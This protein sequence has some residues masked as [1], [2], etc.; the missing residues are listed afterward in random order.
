MTEDTNGTAG[1]KDVASKE[2]EMLVNA[3]KKG[4]LA[5]LFTFVRLSGPGWLQSA[6]TIGGGSLSNSLY[7]GVLVGFGCLWVQPLAMILGVVMLSAITYVT[8]SSEEPPLR[9]INQH[10][11]PILG[12]GWLIASMMANIVWS[13]PQ[14]ALSAGALQ[15]NL[16][17]SFFGWENQAGIFG[18]IKGGTAAAAIIILAIAI[19]NVM[20]YN[21]GGKGTKIFETIIKCVIAAIVI[22]FFGVI[23]KL[24][25]VKDSGLNWGQVAAGLIPNFHHFTKPAAGVAAEIANVVP[26]FQSF[27]SDLVVGLQRDVMIGA[28]STAVGINMTFLLPYSII[29]KGWDRD[30]RG[31]AIFD[32]ATGLVIPF[33]IATGCVVMATASQFHVK[34]AAGFLGETDAQGQIVQPAKNLVGPYKGLMDKRITAGMTAEEKTA[35]SSLPE[36][37]KAVQ[38]EAMPKADKRMA[39]MLVKRDSFNLGDSLAPLLGKGV[40][41][42]I[43]GLG[44]VAMTLNAATMLML[45]NGLCL[46][47][48]LGK[49]AKGV[50]QVIG[51]LI[52]AVGVLGAFFW[53][54]AK[55]WLAVPTSVFC[56]ALLPIAYIAFFLLMN[57][58]KFMGDDMPSGLSRMVWN[59]LMTLSV[60]LTG[61]LS[62]WALWDKGGF[63][64]KNWIGVSETAG[65]FMGLGIFVGF[66]VLVA[67][68]HFM[69][70]AKRA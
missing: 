16:F 32:L 31:L 60:L 6:I 58:K 40:S 55:M 11:S 47:E 3:R 7:L 56:A 57:Q 48:M 13:L 4:G 38:R 36:E 70:S 29:R 20:L 24:S 52:P 33:T 39:A 66:G 12:W 41:K 46:C 14:Y 50:T 64:G 21:R 54:D 18:S 35:Y 10:V 22:C 37:E 25:F 5:T 2:R 23:I 9:A 17:P 19:F 69:R 63:I 45:I 49:P 26:A 34:P 53:N 51:S 62:L 1:S 42:Y 59:V 68:V 65:N 61:A 30:F 27:W 28:A 8:L 67:A 43:F 44:V 15:Q